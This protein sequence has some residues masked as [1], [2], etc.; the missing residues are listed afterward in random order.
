MEYYINKHSSIKIVCD[1]VIYFDPYLIEN[2]K[3]DAD[4]VFI[5]H[6]H[7]DHF[8]PSDI[9]KVLKADTKIVC[10]NTCVD[11][12]KKYFSCVISV[13]VGEQKVI[14]G[15]KVSGIP[16]YNNTKPFHKKENGWLGYIIE[17]EG[18]RIYVAG[19]T[20]L[21]KDN[22]NVSCDVAFLPIGGTYTMD[23][24]EAKTFI[25]KIKPKEVVPTHYGSVVGDIGL[26]Q[27]LKNRLKDFKITLL[28]K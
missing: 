11:E 26:G 4:I 28:I 1:K 9:K 13:S 21:T 24:A 25:E 19:D 5:T 14:D 27:K 8:S 2:T 23:I 12:I 22:E 16:A 7:Y 20:D 18:K 6:T 17:T 15:I 10:P 3:N